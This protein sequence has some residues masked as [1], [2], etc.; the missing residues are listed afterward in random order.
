MSFG[1]VSSAVV[2]AAK[3]ANDISNMGNM[4]GMTTVSQ[5]II[6]TF[7]SGFWGEVILLLS[8][9]TMFAG[10][11]FSGNRKILPVSVVGVIT[12]Y[13]SMYAYFSIS[14]EIIGGIVL[15]F[16]YASAYSRRVARTLK[17]A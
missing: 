3:N 6:V 4:A 1:I 9:G 2:G 8:F 15:A 12:L 16:A 17:L 10:I 5:N 11:W 7:F 14:L 13:V